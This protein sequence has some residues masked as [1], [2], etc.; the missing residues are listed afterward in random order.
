MAENSRRAASSQIESIDKLR[1]VI[2]VEVVDVQIEFAKQFADEFDVVQFDVVQL[3]TVHELGG[4][5]GDKQFTGLEFDNGLFV[6]GLF[7]CVLWWC[8]CWWLVVAF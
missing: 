2:G 6:G 3:E 5:L 8:C 4:T 1:L 7:A